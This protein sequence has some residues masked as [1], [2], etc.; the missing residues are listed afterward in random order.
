MGV[1]MPT[2]VFELLLNEINAIGKSI[3]ETF[4]GISEQAK[5]VGESSEDLA[6]NLDFRRSKDI[7]MVDQL[8]QDLTKR[9]DKLTE[10]IKNREK[11]TN[12]LTKQEKTLIRLQK[13]QNKSTQ[14]LAVSIEE[15]KLERHAATKAA[16]E[17]AKEKLVEQLNAYQADVEKVE[18][19]EKQK[20]VNEEKISFGALSHPF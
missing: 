11:A 6:K 18:K 9:V 7:K 2:S 13:E 10:S 14:E 16:K 17:Q 5:K 19:K 12:I 4:K 15:V 20:K 8:L 1:D 3:E